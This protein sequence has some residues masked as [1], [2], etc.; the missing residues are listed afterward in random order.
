MKKRDGRTLDRW[1]MEM[2]TMDA[3]AQVKAAE[4]ISSVTASYRM[5]LTT[6]LQVDGT[7]GGR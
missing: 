2:I 5:A 1:T 3:V 7:H 4:D 6:Y